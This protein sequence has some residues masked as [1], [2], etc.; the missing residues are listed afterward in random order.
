MHPSSSTG[1]RLQLDHKACMA[2]CSPF[3]QTSVAS[4]WRSFPCRATLH[5]VGANTG[6]MASNNS[7][8]VVDRE[9]ALDWA[10]RL[11]EAME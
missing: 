7:G 8:D 5:L 4:A 2:S 1:W 9:T 6:K 11:Q 3:S 10:C